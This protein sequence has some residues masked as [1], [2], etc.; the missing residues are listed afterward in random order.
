MTTV[1]LGGTFEELHSGHVKLL[2]EAINLGDKILIG[3]TSD[4]FAMKTKKRKITPFKKRKENLL[5]LLNSISKASSKEIE[6]FEINDPYGPA[7][8]EKNIDI[9]VV[10]IE[11]YPRAEEINE[12]RRKKGFK[13]LVIYVINLVETKEGE[14]I[15]STYIVREERDPWGRKLS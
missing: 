4:D 3:L 6:V 2:I 10:S 1:I 8:T 5:K 14:K 7:I 15:S 13:P 11:T 9:I 12:I